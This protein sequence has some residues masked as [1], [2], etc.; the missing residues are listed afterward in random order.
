[1]TRG[2]R[3]ALATVVTSLGAAGVAVGTWLPW[4]VVR[5]GYDGP[6]PA[7][8]L[9]GM[10]AGIE[11]LDWVALAATG[12]ALVGVLPAA[13]F[14][15]VR[16]AAVAMAGGGVVAGTTAVYLVVYGLDYLGVFVPG[17]GFFLTALGGVHLAVGGALRLHALAGE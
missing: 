4:L 11:G 7:I 5:P 9:P 17:A 2:T 6:V 14:R 1:M 10:T 13:R 12:V 8:H 3:S 16:F 15:T